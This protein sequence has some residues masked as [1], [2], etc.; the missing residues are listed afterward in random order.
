MDIPIAP[1]ML[2]LRTGGRY[3][4]KG[5][6]YHNDAGASMGEQE[7]ESFFA[8]LFVQ[9]ADNASIRLRYYQQKDEDGPAAVTFY[10]ARLNDSCSGKSFPG[11]TT[12]GQPTTLTPTDFLCGTIPDPGGRIGF[13]NGSVSLRPSSFTG[14]YANFIAESLVD[15]PSQVEGVPY[16]E[17]NAANLRDWDMTPDEVWY[18]SNP[19]AGDDT[20][21]DVRISSAPDAKWRWLGG[22]NYYQQEFLTSSNGGVFVVACGNLGAFGTPAQCDNPA[23]IPVGVDGGVFVDVRAFYGSLSY[24]LTP[25]WTVDLEARWQDDTR[26]DGIGDFEWPSRTSCLK[27]ACVTAPPKT[28]PCTSP[29]PRAFF[30]A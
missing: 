1:G 6:M 22:F 9:A 30:Q 14:Q 27:S 10:K 17:N 25:Q 18:V 12:N 21:V 24:D 5:A 20:S 26:S 19:Q 15:A 4:N 11:L 7:S 28:L 13:P 29:R 2:A 23:R 8:T 3:Y 16:N